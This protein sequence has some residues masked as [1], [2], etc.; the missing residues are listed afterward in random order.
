[1]LTKR[2]LINVITKPEVVEHL[3]PNVKGFDIIHYIKEECNGMGPKDTAEK[4][5]LKVQFLCTQDMF[6]KV[7]DYL[8]KYYVK[9]FGIILYYEDV[10]VSM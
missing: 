4:G 6:S 3:I 2:F 10:H 8:E 1:M 9:D 5:M 7:W